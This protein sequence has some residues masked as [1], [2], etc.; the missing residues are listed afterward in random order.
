MAVREWTHA[1]KTK[2]GD[3]PW[4]SEPDKV[5]WIDEATGLDCLIHRAPLG[6]WCGYV[7][8]AEGHP[9]FGKDYGQ[10]AQPTPCEESWCQHSP[11]AVLNPH[12]GI[13]YAAF[14]QET[15][16]ESHGIC[17][18]PEDGRPHRVWW[19]GFDCAHLGDYSPGMSQYS[20]GRQAVRG[21]IYKDRAYVEGEVRQLAQH[22]SALLPPNEKTI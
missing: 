21:E 1:D 14:C 4:N 13:T 16:G 15:G 19:L 18:V 9:F 11:A 22:L 7:G 5:Q 2:W 6:H 3:G 12:G 17:H 10:C 8:V 20:A